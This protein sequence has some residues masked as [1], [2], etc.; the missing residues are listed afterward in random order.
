MFKNF[1]MM[2][3]KGKNVQEFRNDGEKKRVSAKSVQEFRN[4]GEKKGK[5]VQEFRNEENER[6]FKIK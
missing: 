3:K 5:N 6:F 2:A 4:N 1:E